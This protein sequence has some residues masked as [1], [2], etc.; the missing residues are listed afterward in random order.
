MSILVGLTVA[1][2]GCNK[3]LIMNSYNDTIFNEYIVRNGLSD[4][5]FGQEELNFWFAFNAFDNL[6]DPETDTDVIQN[7][8]FE[9]S[10]KSQ[11]KS[12]RFDGECCCK[13]NC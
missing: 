5:E 11:K 3:F 8:G 12:D 4:K 9:K 7:V 10:K 6:Y 13:H 1:L 2:Y